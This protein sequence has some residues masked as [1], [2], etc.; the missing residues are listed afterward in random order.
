M[1]TQHT[2]PEVTKESKLIS[3]SIVL[4]IWGTVPHTHK[5]TDAGWKITKFQQYMIQLR[6]LYIQNNRTY[7][8][9]VLQNHSCPHANMLM[10]NLA[11]TIQCTCRAE[12]TEM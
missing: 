1:G 2:Q 7:T 11:M 5:N 12:T 9:K 3:R 4:I 8:N 10:S 6:E